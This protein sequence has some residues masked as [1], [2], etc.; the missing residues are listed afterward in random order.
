M[1]TLDA[2]TREKD[3]LVSA[4]MTPSYD[5][6]ENH[7]EDYA[8]FMKGLTE[9]YRGRNFLAVIQRELIDG[10]NLRADSRRNKMMND[11]V[12]EIYEEVYENSELTTFV[13]NHRDGHIFRNCGYGNLTVSAR[14]DVCF[15]GRVYDVKK[16]ANIRDT[17]IDEIMRLRKSVRHF[18]SV[19]CVEPCR[20][21]DL[22]YVCGGGCRVK[23]FPESVIAGSDDFGRR[24]F[25][26]ATECSNDDKD[27]L[28]RLM[29]ESNKFLMR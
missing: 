8:A 24:V 17:S 16:Y 11:I 27:R 3:I 2:F 7:R 12:S 20:D 1:R 28:Y 26:R 25:T 18:T 10:R 15:C 13:M 5:S 21:C 19:D 4:I 9:K 22:K 23:N 14:G 6:L 29:I